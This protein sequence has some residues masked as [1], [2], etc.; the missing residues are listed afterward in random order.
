MDNFSYVYPGKTWI[1]LEYDLSSMCLCDDVLKWTQLLANKT[2]SQSFMKDCRNKKDSLGIK[3]TITLRFNF[4]H[5][6]KKMQY[7]PI[8]TKFQVS[9]NK[10][11]KDSTRFKKSLIFFK[12]NIFKVKKTISFELNSLN[13][14]VY[15]AKGSH[16]TFLLSHD[17]KKSK[18]YGPKF[19]I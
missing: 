12:T 16:L 2:K 17:Y 18:K 4:S 15:T 13:R 7:D 3:A 11:L 14:F 10:V 9:R 5:T 8:H 1:Q 19:I 6:G